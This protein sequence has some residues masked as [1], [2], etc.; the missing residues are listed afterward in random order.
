LEI[1]VKLGAHTRSQLQSR[2]FILDVIYVRCKPLLCSSEL[3]R[4]HNI[5]I[6]PLAASLS[7]GMA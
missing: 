2:R 3:Y 4:Y 7:P 5:M 1:V 6:N